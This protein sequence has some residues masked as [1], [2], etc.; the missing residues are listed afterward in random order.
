MP[1]FIWEARTKAGEVRSGT[2]NADSEDAVTDR[3]RA[4]GLTITKVKRKP[5]EL[6]LPSLGSG[7]GLKD[8]VVFT[9]TFSTMIDAGLPIVSGLEM[10]SNQAENPRFGRI[11]AGVKSEVESGKSLSEG[12]ASHPRVFDDLFRNL[13][14]AGEAGGILDVIFRRL[15]VYLEKA[16]KLR[17][18]VRG[19]LVYPSVIMG[20]GAL[21]VF[22]MMTKVLPVFEK[23]FVD[24]GAGSLPAPTRMV[25]AISHAITDNIIVFTLVVTAIVVGFVA[26]MRTDKG[27]YA[28]D[29]V[30]LRFPVIGPVMRKIAVARFTRTLGTLLSS[31]VPILDALDIVAKSAGNKVVARA[32]LYARAKISEGKDIASPLL[33]TGVFPP[34]V[35]QMIG[36][37]EQTGA[38]DDMLQK[39]ADFYEEEVDAGV[40]AMTALLE[41]LML[42]LLGGVVG[43]LL[44][45]MYLP[46][47]E[48]AGNIK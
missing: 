30:I 11:L 45:A 23:M 47:F 19:A 6:S 39:I 4:Q 16:A 22:I 38:M 9:R 3:L 32:I 8:M 43:G 15:A 44:I 7:V 37:G 18:Q 14:A 21:V 2:F 28:F 31:G 48:V 10:L 41:P 35:V 17:R 1:T 29:T 34:M 25:L 24:L 42:V 26:I 12:M 33:E 27:R 20:V 13:V 40:S 46:I 5:M 36:V